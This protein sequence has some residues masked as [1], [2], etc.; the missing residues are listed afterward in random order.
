MAASFVVSS[1]F[2][3]RPEWP[4]TSFPKSL[5]RVRSD[6][7]QPALKGKGLHDFIGAHNENFH[8]WDGHFLFAKTKSFKSSEFLL[9]YSFWI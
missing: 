6:L 1:L 5:T 7:R 4:I 3:D 2:C 8:G 9:T